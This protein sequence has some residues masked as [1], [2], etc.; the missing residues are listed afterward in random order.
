[1]LPCLALVPQSKRQYFLNVCT[2]VTILILFLQN[3]ALHAFKY[4]VV[5]VVSCVI[6][7]VWWQNFVAP[8]VLFTGILKLENVSTSLPLFKA[9]HFTVVHPLKS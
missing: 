6:P 7:A 9:F 3:V 2:T 5:L 1:V 8:M 4:K